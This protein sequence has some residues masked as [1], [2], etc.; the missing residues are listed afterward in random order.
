[1]LFSNGV[2]T[3]LGEPFIVRIRIR[4]VQEHEAMWIART[5]LA[6]DIGLVR[7]GSSKAAGRLEVKQVRMVGTRHRPTFI[8]GLGLIACRVIQ[9]E[10]A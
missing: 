2:L 10:Q 9:E 7:L 1:M 5:L 4:D 8:K 6:I 3:K